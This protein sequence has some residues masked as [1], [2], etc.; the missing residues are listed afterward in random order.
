M[1]VHLV[2]EPDSP[3]HRG[4]CPRC[5]ATMADDQRYCLVCGERRGDPRVPLVRDA[6][7]VPAAAVPPAAVVPPP[8]SAAPL[9]VGAVAVLLIAM[10][11]GVLIGRSGHETVTPARS[12]A[13]I[14]VKVPAAGAAAPAAAKPVK[15]AAATKKKAAKQ[16]KQAPAATVDKQQLQELDKLSPEQYQ[17]KSK[18]LPKTLGTGGK[19]PP[20]D[21]K[22]AG[23]GSGFEEIG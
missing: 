13:P 9:W 16:A 8:R 22:P 18:A 4:K 21:S 14:T 20:K 2:P 12:A 11:V 19:A 7:P 6:P 5:S 10:G 15:K 3:T 17:K 1:T 23:G